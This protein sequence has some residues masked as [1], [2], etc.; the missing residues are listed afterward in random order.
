MCHFLQFEDEILLYHLAEQNN[1]L[2]DFIFKMTEEVL[3]D[4]KLYTVNCG[5]LWK[6]ELLMKCMRETEIVVAVKVEHQVV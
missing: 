5:I 6:S 1:E 4:K 3:H 2:E